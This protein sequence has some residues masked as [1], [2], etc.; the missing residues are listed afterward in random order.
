MGGVGWGGVS[1]GGCASGCLCVDM[2]V[3][4]VCVREGSMGV[5]VEGI[6]R[7][8]C[9]LR[10]WSSVPEQVMKVWSVSDGSLQTESTSLHGDS[11]IT[12]LV[13]DTSGRR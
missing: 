12:S 8:V 10:I 7:G 3:K 9:V 4:C 1:M 6:S 2:C 13:L 5:C 11:P